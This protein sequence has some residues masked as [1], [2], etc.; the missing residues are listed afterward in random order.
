MNFSI[1]YEL[2]ETTNKSLVVDE[3]EKRNDWRITNDYFDTGRKQLAQRV[4]FR[5][6]PGGRRLFSAG[7]GQNRSSKGRG[8]HAGQNTELVP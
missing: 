2:E 8:L 5:F 7:G 3:S 4:L 1:N 6:F